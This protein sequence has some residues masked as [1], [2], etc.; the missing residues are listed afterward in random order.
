MS[1]GEVFPPAEIDAGRIINGHHRIAANLVLGR[2]IDFKEI[3]FYGPGE[4]LGGSFFR[5]IQIRP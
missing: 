4:G 5:D 1:A 2:P 3:G